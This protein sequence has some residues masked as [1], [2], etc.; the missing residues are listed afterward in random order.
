VDYTWSPV[1]DWRETKEVR[2]ATGK[3]AFGQLPMYEEPDGFVLVQSN[4]IIRYLAN[5]HGLNGNNAHEAAHIDQIN[6]G[7]VDLYG[8][9]IQIQFYTREE[10]AK[11]EAKAKFVKETLPGQLG[12]FDA[13]AAKNKS[14]AFFV[15][16]KLSYADLTF[17]DFVGHIKDWPGVT[18]AIAAHPH[19]KA[20]LDKI[21]STPN[22]KH[23]LESS[24]Y[25]GGH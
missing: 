12:Y 7:V 21:T 24:P 4:A 16:D 15:G 6:E 2:I 1:N 13:I 14:H 9:F 8:K 11:A 17:F 3:Y 10:E 5:K 25:G 23:Y 18:E 19:V 20:V 22:I